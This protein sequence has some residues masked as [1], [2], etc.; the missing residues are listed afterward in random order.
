MRLYLNQWITVELPQTIESAVPQTIESPRGS[1]PDNR[2]T[3][4][5]A[6]DDRVTTP[7]VPQTIESRRRCPRRSSSPNDRSCPRRSSRRWRCPTRSSCRRRC[8]RQSNLRRRLPQRIGCFPGHPSEALVRGV[9]SSSASAFKL[10]AGRSRTV[11]EAIAS[12]PVFPC[13]HCTRRSKLIRPADPVARPSQPPPERSHPRRPPR[14]GRP[15]A[16]TCS[17]ICRRPSSHCGRQ[18]RPGLQHQRRGAADDPRRH[19]RPDN[20]MYASA[21]LPATWRAGYVC[22]RYEPVDSA[23]TMRH[24]RRRRGPA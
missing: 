20:C 1:T 16:G 7:R 13:T 12:R 8:P 15:T 9:D 23:Q 18:P 2:V 4:G 24:A 17:S 3:R 19:A 14:P 11:G 22:D 5:G 21:P 6:P 10:L